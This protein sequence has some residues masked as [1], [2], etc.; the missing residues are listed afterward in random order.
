MHVVSKDFD[1]PCL[2]HKKHW[3]SFNT[4]FLVTAERVKKDLLDHER[5]IKPS[6]EVIQ[7]YLNTPLKCNTCSYI[8]KHMPDLKKHLSSHTKDYVGKNNSFLHLFEKSS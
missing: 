4:D 7:K 2:K 5:V 6:D 1:S 8:P 3:N